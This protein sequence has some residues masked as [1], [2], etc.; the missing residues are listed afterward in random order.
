MVNSD[1]EE[2]AQAELAKRRAAPKE[3][4]RAPECTR[5]MC[6]RCFGMDGEGGRHHETRGRSVDPRR[7]SGARGD[8]QG[9]RS[10]EA[11]AAAHPSAEAGDS[12]VNHRLTPESF[13]GLV[14]YV[15]PKYPLNK[16]RKRAPRRDVLTHM[17]IMVEIFG[18]EVHPSIN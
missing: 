6:L 13:P 1:A 16:M 3:E 7:L 12:C 11:V 18:R 17:G 8:S 4:P 5:M 15:R 2:R 14:S 9:D 10:P